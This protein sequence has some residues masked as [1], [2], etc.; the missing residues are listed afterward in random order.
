MSAGAGRRSSGAAGAAGAALPVVAA[1]AATLALSG[2]A[3]AD[4]LALVRQACGHVDKSL[5]LYESSTVTS[6]ASVAQSDDAAALQQLRDAL[7]LAATAAGEDATWQAFVTTLSESNRVPESDLVR[8]LRQQC[9]A[10]SSGGPGPAL[11]STSVAP[12][13]T[14]PVPVGQ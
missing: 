14:K 6:S 9:A 2:C 3:H 1:V 5:A 10:V 13:P 7:P 8:A 4:A 12:V 11:T